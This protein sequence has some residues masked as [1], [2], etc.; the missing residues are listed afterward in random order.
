MGAG[1][2]FLISCKTCHRV[3]DEEDFDFLFFNVCRMVYEPERG[4]SKTRPGPKSRPAGPHS[5][6]FCST[7]NGKKENE[8]STKIK[9]GRERQGRGQGVGDHIHV[10]GA[11]TDTSKATECSGPLEQD[12]LNNKRRKP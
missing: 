10:L 5:C 2:C 12:E 9:E 8:R 11:V 7:N 1:S 4:M 3:K 6:R